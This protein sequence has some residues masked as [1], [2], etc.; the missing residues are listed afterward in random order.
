M[1]HQWHKGVLTASSWHGLEEIGTMASADEQIAHGERC[2]AWPITLAFDTVQTAGGF[3]APGRGVLA[4]Y[5]APH[6]TRCLSVV[7]DDYRATTP[8]EWRQLVRAAV[9]AGARPTGAFSLR[10]GARVLATFEVG[11]ANGLR[12]QFMLADSFDGSLRLTG[13]ST[14][15]R[16]VC[17][18]T[19]SLAMGTDG[20][21]MARLKHTSSL[22][23]KVQ[24]LCASIAQAI[25]T[26][27]MVREVYERAE[28][29]R[30]SQEQ[31]DRA[32]RLLFPDPARD[33][34]KAS[35]TRA[36]NARAEAWEAARRAENNAGQTAATV[37][38]AAT[39]LVDRE[40]DGS[41][42]KLRGD[43]DRLDALVFGNRGR[44]VEEIMTIVQVVMRDGTIQEVPA[45]RALDMGVDPRLVA[46]S[47]I[48]DICAAADGPTA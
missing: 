43:G 13:G 35:K 45:P 41:A 36:E 1:A 27:E 11:K 44:R 15:V 16:V 17:A 4:T 47:V 37:W 9:D 34:S 24:A 40:A 32:M 14:S 3:R 12:T 23:D 8:E 33:A 22:G 29:T 28:K 25:E 26:G 31:A 7:G 19:L 5:A 42:R 10:D 21:G 30:L 20:G 18:N 46:R 6:A 39:W 48:D 38:N 2:G